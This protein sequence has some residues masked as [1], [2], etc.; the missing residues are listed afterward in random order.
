MR[1]I[2]E[3]IGGG[4]QRAPGNPRAPRSILLAL[5]IVSVPAAL[6]AQFTFTTNN[7][8]LTIT[9]YTGPGGDV[10]IPDTTNGMP[11]TSIG[12]SAFYGQTSPT[13][14]AIPNSVTNIG[15]YAFY[16]CTSLI[17]ITIP[18]SVTNIGSSAF[19]S[20]T[21]LNAITVDV[22]ST[23]YSSLDGVLFNKGTNTLIQCPG[24]KAGS[25]TVPNGVTNIGFRAFNSCISLTS[26]TIGNGVTR[27]KTKR[28]S[29]APA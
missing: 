5:V 23:A 11:V 18:N 26:V 19:A 12:N 6:Q 22:L 15:S 10:T 17:S 28:S 21:S 9:G 25:Y 27:I 4:S 24:G 3:S 20:C 2:E 8:A 16:Y 13:S 7:G 1:A 29:R 14:V